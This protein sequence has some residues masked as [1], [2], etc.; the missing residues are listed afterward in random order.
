MGA[1]SLGQDCYAARSSGVGEFSQRPFRTTKPTLTAFF[2]GPSEK[3][4]CQE[5]GR[6]RRT[7]KPENSSTSDLGNRST[8]E[9]PVP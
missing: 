5:L 7:S 9:I 1:R 6:Y 3:H 2:L 4:R 8:A